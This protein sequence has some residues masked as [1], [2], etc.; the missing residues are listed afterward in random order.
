MNWNA[1]TKFCFTYALMGGAWLED[2]SGYRNWEPFSMIEKHKGR[3][4]LDANLRKQG[5]CTGCWIDV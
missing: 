1:I 5:I 4:W 3:A 2:A